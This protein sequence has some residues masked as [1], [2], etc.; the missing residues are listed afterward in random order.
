MSL[1]IAEAALAL[2]AFY[3]QFHANIISY[4]A[5]T[6]AEMLNEIQ[7]GVY[8]YLLPEYDRS[9]VREKGDMRK[10]RFCCPEE[11]RSPFAKSL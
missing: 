5:S 11:V 2:E 4:H 8:F 3:T 1:T 7:W 9:F 6:I 10:Y